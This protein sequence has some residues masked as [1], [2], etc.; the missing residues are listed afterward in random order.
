[1]RAQRKQLNLPRLKRKGA[2]RAPCL[3]TTT[4]PPGDELDF[5][6]P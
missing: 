4:P 1:M 3:S 5:D 6:Y 2:L